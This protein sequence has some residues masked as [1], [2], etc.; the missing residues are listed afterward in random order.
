MQSNTIENEVDNLST[1]NDKDVESLTFVRNVSSPKTSERYFVKHCM[2]LIFNIIFKLKCF[3]NMV[4]GF[5]ENVEVDISLTPK[6]K[7]S[8]FFF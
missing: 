6:I 3:S 4:I 5:Q 7:I 1:S 2:H 8:N